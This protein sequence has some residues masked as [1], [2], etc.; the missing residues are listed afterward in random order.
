[1]WHGTQALCVSLGVVVLN[2]SRV[3]V[4]SSALRASATGALFLLGAVCHIRFPFTLSVT[5]LSLP[6]ERNLNSF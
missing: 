5:W 4:P 2:A 3:G 1:M 6:T